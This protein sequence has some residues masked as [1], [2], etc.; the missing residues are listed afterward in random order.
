MESLAEKLRA[1]E[2]DESKANVEYLELAAAAEQ[3][4][5]PDMATA[6]R[7]IAADEAR[8]KVMLQQMVGSAPAKSPGVDYV[9][10]CLVVHI[11]EHEA[12]GSGRVVDEAKAKS[13]PCKCFRFEGDEFCWSPGVLGLISSKKNPG[14]MEEFCALG[15]EPA[16]AGAQKHFNKI[17]QAVAAAHQEWEK[18]GGGLKSWWR[19]VADQMAEIGLE[20]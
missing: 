20:V 8:H 15:K 6:L 7:S 3:A 11:L 18:Q 17:K 2:E 12:A 4:G 9:T 10:S 13:T 5:R 16:S 1:E 19:N 14:Q